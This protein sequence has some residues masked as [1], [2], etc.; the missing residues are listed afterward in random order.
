MKSFCKI[1]NV[2]L[3]W[4]DISRLQGCLVIAVL[5]GCQKVKP[6][7]IA[8]PEYPDLKEVYSSQAVALGTRSLNKDVSIGDKS[9]SKTMSMD[10]LK[11]KDE[12]S[13]L[14]EMNPNQSEYVGVF[15]IVEDGKAKTL[16]LKEGE[17]SILKNISFTSAG[18]SYSRIT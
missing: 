4:F 13:F 1:K 2:P 6:E 12:L 17:K 11:W 16:T 7:F 9:E 15:A 18:E 10:S 8:I 14:L 3:R 5:L